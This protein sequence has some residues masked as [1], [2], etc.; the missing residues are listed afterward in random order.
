MTG[1]Q[2]AWVCVT[3]CTRGEQEQAVAGRVGQLLAAYNAGWT[4]AAGV[5]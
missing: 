4:T 2:P 1:T 3:F 5:L